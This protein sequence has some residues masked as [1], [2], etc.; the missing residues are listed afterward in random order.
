MHIFLP[1]LAAATVWAPVSKVPPDGA[2]LLRACTAAMQMADGVQLGADDSMRAVWCVGYVSGVLDGLAVL[3]WKGG[4]T[5]VC[6]PEKGITNDQAARLVVRYLRSH[7]DVLHESA[8]A[9]VVVAIAETF[10]CKA[11]R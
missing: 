11:G 4:S 8:R 1:L 2:E 7:P 6:L 5:R 9:S 10:A 3:G